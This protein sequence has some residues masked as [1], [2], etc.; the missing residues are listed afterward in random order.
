MK[1]F[2]ASLFLITFN[3]NASNAVPHDLSPMGMFLM[4]DWVVKSVIILLLFASIISWTI[5]SVKYRE[6]SNLKTQLS[7]S[8]YQFTQVK[9]LNELKALNSLCAVS[10]Q[11]IEAPFYELTLSP[12]NMPN[13]GIKERIQMALIDIEKQQKKRMNSQLGFLATVGSTAPFIGLF[14]TVWGIMNSFI[15]ISESN[16]T[17]LAVVAPGIAEALFATALGLVAA[18]PAV[19]LYNLFSRKVA[20]VAGQLNDMS[21][22]IN[23]L[24]S[25]E[26]DLKLLTKY[27]EYDHAI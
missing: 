17:D 1:L 8:L 25:R 2:L 19:M 4:A 11:M 5:A 16:T 9:R 18:I 13:Q 12:E 24:V 6:V 20:H 15:G 22:Y 14:G 21:V 27:H 3:A 7:K 23:R 10:K 26:L